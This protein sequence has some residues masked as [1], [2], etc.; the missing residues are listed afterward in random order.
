MA[1]NFGK[2]PSPELIL[3]WLKLLQLQHQTLD[4]GLF[5]AAGLSLSMRD[6]RMA[7]HLPDPA[8]AQSQLKPDR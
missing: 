8:P 2:M 7:S 1:E 3:T 6:R 5:R 4:T